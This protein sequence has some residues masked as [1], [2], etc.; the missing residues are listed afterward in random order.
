MCPGLHRSPTS[1][2]LAR[3]EKSNGWNLRVRLS[4]HGF[5]LVELIAAT[6]I[7]L[8]LATIALP[9]A[10]IQIVRGR[11]TELRRDLREM[12]EAIDHYKGFADQGLIP[13]KAN[14][15][16][17]GYPPDLK[18]LVEGVPIKGN[19]TLKYKFLRRV[20]SDPMTGTTDWGF[21]SVQD[22][23]DSRGWGG[24]NVFDVYSKSGG[25]ALDGTKYEDW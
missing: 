7:L 10:R 14:A 6:A 19:A 18:S 23:P 13:G 8:V 12:R 16:T 2:F 9:M 20:P 15:D 1:Q 21:R 11:E 5:M 17:Y 3:S 4:E 25:V 24:Q 22:D